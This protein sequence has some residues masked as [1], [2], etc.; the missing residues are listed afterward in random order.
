[1]ELDKDQAFWGK[2]LLTAFIVATL[3]I[4]S[5]NA[6]IDYRISKA[7]E[8]G[9]DPVLAR[10]AFV[11]GDGGYERVMHIANEKVN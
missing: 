4:G 9:V 8:Q 1:M 3:T 6:H 5:C 7:I 10:S 2:I 11:C